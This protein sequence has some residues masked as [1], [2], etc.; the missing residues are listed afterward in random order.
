MPYTIDEITGAWYEAYGEYMKDE[1]AGF[2]EI[3]E[4]PKKEKERI[5]EVGWCTNIRQVD[6]QTKGVKK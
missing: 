1:Y 2:F 3:I 6:A 4:K 5:A